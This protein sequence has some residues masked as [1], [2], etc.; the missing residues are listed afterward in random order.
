MLMINAS[1]LYVGGGMQVGMSVIEEFTLMDLDFIAAVSPPIYSQLTES[2][3]KK[4]LIIKKTPSGL[5]NFSSRKLLNKM[6]QEYNI[7]AVFTV[8]GPSYWT[9]KVKNHTV[10]FALP[11]LI[12]NS[13]QVFKKL[14]LIQKVKKIILKYLQP[15]YYRLNA[16]KIVVETNDVKEH[17]YSKLGFEMNKVFVVSNSVSSYFTRDYVLDEKIIERLPKKIAGDI[18]LLTV[19]YNYPHKNLSV[20]FDLLE[21]LP[22]HYKFVLTL[23][24]SFIEGLS[25]EK[26]SRFILVGNVE[27]KQCPALYSY[28]DAVLLP[29]LLECF[30]A[31]YIEA[32]IM[33]KPIFTSNRGFSKTICGEGAFYFNPLDP[34]DMATTITAAFEKPDQIISKCNLMFDVHKKLPDAK[35]RAEMYLKIISEK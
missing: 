18:W 13:S 19:S 21:L 15:Y 33:R 30:S 9:P 32:G 22:N 23:E 5:F 4:C 31:S 1:N 26:K 34:K 7:D 27:N 10:G 3:K 16:T 11:W 8:F 2:A 28:S 25:E 20:I 14:T 24:K 17:L 35:Q 29:T 6:V 12:Y